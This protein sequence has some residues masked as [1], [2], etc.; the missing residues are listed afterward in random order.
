MPSKGF[1]RCACRVCGTEFFPSD[2]ADDIYCS[3]ACRHAQYLY[4]RRTEAFYRAMREY[5]E[6][7]RPS[8]PV[9]PTPLRVPSAEE[10]AASKGW[11]RNKTKARSSEPSHHDM[12]YVS[13]KRMYTRTCHTC[14]RPCSNY[15]CSDCWRDRRRKY[16]IT[17]ASAWGADEE[18]DD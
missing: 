3:P 8:R 12:R 16:G 1:R 2:G 5:D 15:W 7:K 11:A 9:R 4:D 10:R 17:D 6:G 18:G 13:Y 14:G